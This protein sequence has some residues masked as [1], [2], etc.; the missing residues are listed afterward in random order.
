MRGKK[1]PLTASTANILN[2]KVPANLELILR[3]A[4]FHRKRLVN[5]KIHKIPMPVRYHTVCF[6]LA[7]QI[8][9]IRPH[10]RSIHA[11]LTGRA[12]ATLHVPQN[13]RPRLN[14][15][16]RF[17]PLCQTL[18]ISNPFCIDNNMVLLAAPAVLNNMV[19]QLLLVIII[20]L[21]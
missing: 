14:A 18:R 5:I 4:L 6:S 8:H 7:Q 19:Y 10:N 2:R 12:P 11:V 17:N 1:I 16:G 21:R 20:P 9:R 15:G 13:S 3:D